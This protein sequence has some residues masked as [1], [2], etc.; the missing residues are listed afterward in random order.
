MLSNGYLQKWRAFVCSKYYT[1]FKKPRLK[2]IPR[3]KPGASKSQPL[4]AAHT[5]IGNAWEYPPPRG[6][7]SRDMERIQYLFCSLP[8]V[9]LQNE[10]LH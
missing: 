9:K 2:W 8:W 6:C 7:R 3:A 1:P 4:W 5:R 10:D